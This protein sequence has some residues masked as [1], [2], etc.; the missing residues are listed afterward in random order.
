MDRVASI[1]GSGWHNGPQKITKGGRVRP[2]DFDFE[3][4]YPA[5]DRRGY[6][7][8]ILGGRDEA[9]LCPVGFAAQPFNM[10]ALVWVM[11][12]KRSG[13]DKHGTEAAQSREEFLGTPNPGKGQ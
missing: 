2:T 11:V 13:I 9:R 10:G 6:S 5:P 1:V 7:D 4:L 8:D 12:G 3:H